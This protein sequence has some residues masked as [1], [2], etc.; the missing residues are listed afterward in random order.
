[1]KNLPGLAAI[2]I[3]LGG[4]PAAAEEMELGISMA[5]MDN[6]N[7]ITVGSNL[8]HRADGERNAFLIKEEESASPE[9]IAVIERNREDRE[10]MVVIDR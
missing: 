3:A 8:N 10:R 7:A 2:M 5:S 4:I 6:P 9:T 1:M